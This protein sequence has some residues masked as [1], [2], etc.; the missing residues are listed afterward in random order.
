MFFMLK[1]KID[2]EDAWGNEWDSD[3][4]LCLSTGGSFS[5]QRK[6]ISKFLQQANVTMNQTRSERS[7]SRKRSLSKVWNLQRFAYSIV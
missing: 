3:G 4:I 7:N 5:E 6:N 1:M 2:R